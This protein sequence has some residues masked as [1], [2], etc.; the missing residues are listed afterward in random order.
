[1][2]LVSGKHYET[3]Q[4]TIQCVLERVADQ[5]QCSV[6]IEPRY[7]RGRQLRVHKSVLRKLDEYL[8]SPR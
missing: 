7:S 5:F 3:D 6:P 1:M 4:G 8:N 2:L